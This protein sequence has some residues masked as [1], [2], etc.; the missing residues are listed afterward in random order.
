MRAAK[1]RQWAQL[2]L[3]S[4]LQLVQVAVKTTVVG[5]TKI[6]AD[7][8][9]W[10]Q[11]NAVREAEV[12]TQLSSHPNI[13]TTYTYRIQGQARP[14]SPLQPVLQDPVKAPWQLLLVQVHGLPPSPP[15]PSL[16]FKSANSC[17]C[18]AML[19]LCTHY[20]LLPLL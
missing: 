17:C 14:G 16:F 1:S 2:V 18:Y 10:V 8:G 12:V 13:V 4:L 15:L 9:S 6:S 19:F 11:G 5:F 7:E 3:P 20:Y